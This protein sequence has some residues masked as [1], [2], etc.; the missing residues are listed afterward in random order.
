MASPTQWDMSL[1]KLWE[2]V[3]DGEAGILQSMGYKELDTTK[4]LSWT[5][6]RFVHAHMSPYSVS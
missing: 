4:R 1:S 5:E 3:M 6:H 2:I